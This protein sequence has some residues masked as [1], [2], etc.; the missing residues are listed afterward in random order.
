ML[1]ETE[2]SIRASAEDVWRVLTDFSQHPTW[3]PFIKSISGTLAKGATL[4]LHVKPPGSKHGMRFKPRVLSVEP[5]KELSW[6]GKLLV[7][8]LFDGEHYF[9]LEALAMNETRLIHG[10]KIHGLLVPFLASTLKATKAGF[11]LMNKA[12]KSKAESII[13]Q[14]N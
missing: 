1:I 10:E 12:L 9:R 4:Q 7:P 2:I 6:K 13:G 14:K 3:N 5:G 11:I 8:G